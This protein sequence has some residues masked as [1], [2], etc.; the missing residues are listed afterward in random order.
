M[1]M[2][3]VMACILC[4]DFNRKI[5]QKCL[6]TLALADHRSI[7]KPICPLLFTHSLYSLSLPHFMP[8][9]NVFTF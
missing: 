9:L 2:K 1:V 7:S 4:K 8:L 6:M 5:R 3:L